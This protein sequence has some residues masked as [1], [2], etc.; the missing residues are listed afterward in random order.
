MIPP[1]ITT[2][3]PATYGLRG[4]RPT[5]RNEPRRNSRD[6]RIEQPVL[7]ELYA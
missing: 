5:Q 6:E 7:A 4:Q 3:D 2:D 1:A